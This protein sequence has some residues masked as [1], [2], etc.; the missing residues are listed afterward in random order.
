[1]AGA[2]TSVPAPP[3]L[4][5]EISL[6]CDFGNSRPNGVGA[7]CVWPPVAD[8]G[9]NL[10]A[11]SS[12]PSTDARSTAAWAKRQ[13]FELYPFTDHCLETF[14]IRSL[15]IESLIHDHYD[16]VVDRSQRASAERAGCCLPPASPMAVR[17][18]SCPAKPLHLRTKPCCLPPTT[19]VRRHPCDSVICSILLS[20]CL[21]CQSRRSSAT[22]ACGRPITKDDGYLTSR[23]CATSLLF[24]N[25]IA[26][27]L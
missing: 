18:S 23:C 5:W 1:M 10:P 2:M 21:P 3:R 8:P 6:T 20:S 12:L 4:S 26:G 7:F 14:G 24:S 17:K 9:G 22:P 11:H 13:P 19:M 27:C 15:Y 25:L 16:T